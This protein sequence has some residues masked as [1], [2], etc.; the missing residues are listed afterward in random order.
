[1]IK[2]IKRLYDAC[3]VVSVFTIILGA[4]GHQY[5]TFRLRCLI[6]IGVIGLS[7]YIFQKASA[8]EDEHVRLGYR[9]IFECILILIIT[10]FVADALMVLNYVKWNNE[11]LFSAVNPVV[12]CIVI[13]DC[14]ATLFRMYKNGFSFFK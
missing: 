9:I 5:I 6:G 13:V 10:L 14:I 2:R 7:H 4:L 1:M 11:L 12:L 8:S 3:I